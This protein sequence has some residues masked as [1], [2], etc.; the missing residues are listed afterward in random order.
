MVWYSLRAV[1]QSEII[2]ECILVAAE[3]EISYVRSEIVEKYG[4]HKVKTLLA[5]GCERWESVGNAVAALGEEPEKEGYVFIHDG[6]RPFLSEEIL[7][8]TYEAVRKY[9]ACVAAVPS[10]DTVK[11][12]DEAGFAASTPD[13]SR[14]WIVQTPQVFETGLI[15]GAYRELQRRALKIG[16]ENIE[17]TDDASVVE[18]FTDRR[19]RLTEGSYRNIKVTTPEDM[20]IAEAFLNSKAQSSFS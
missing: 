12:S 3:D 1:E 20:K 4:F 17:V 14:V 16:R 6:A 11:L 10:K 18:G 9:G 8:R 2:D 13:R 19:V 15:V 5:G 7:S